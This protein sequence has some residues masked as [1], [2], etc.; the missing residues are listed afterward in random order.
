MYIDKTEVIEVKKRRKGR[1]KIRKRSTR[2]R[3]GDSIAGDLVWYWFLVDSEARV[4]VPASS[5]EHPHTSLLEV[6]SV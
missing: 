5:L 4:G 2:K 6:G 3:E 1:N